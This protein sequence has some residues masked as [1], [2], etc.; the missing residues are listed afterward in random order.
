VT[1]QDRRLRKRADELLVVIS[2]LQNAQTCKRF[3]ALAHVFGFAMQTRPGGSMNLVADPL[4]ILSE[5]IPASRGHPETMDQYNDVRLLHFN[6]PSLLRHTRSE[7][8]R[9][10]K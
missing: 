9:V 2:D 3:W 4:K 8:R 5:R 7:E 6:V 1:D 10:G